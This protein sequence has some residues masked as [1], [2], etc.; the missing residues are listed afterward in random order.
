MDGSK[1]DASHASFASMQVMKPANRTPGVAS[2]IRREG[3][4]D[5]LKS[6]APFTQSSGAGRI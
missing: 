5:D 2:E 4:E 1:M 6:V 3:P